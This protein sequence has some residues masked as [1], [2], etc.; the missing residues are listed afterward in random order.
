MLVLL[1][2][3]LFLKL[4][5]LLL[6]LFHDCLMLFLFPLFPLLLLL[7]CV[8]PFRSCDTSACKFLINPSSSE[9][10]CDAE[11]IRWLALSS[12]DSPDTFDCS[13]PDMEFAMCCNTVWLSDIACSTVLWVL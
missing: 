4:D 6:L 5:D 11:F 3:L 13:S 2:L 8:L 7:F 9:L 10:F 12:I 1:F